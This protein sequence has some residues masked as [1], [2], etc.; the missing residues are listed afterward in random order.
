MEDMFIIITIKDWLVQWLFRLILLCIWT[1]V[2]EIQSGYF[3]VILYEIR[4]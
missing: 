2:Q 3:K 4:I 1:C